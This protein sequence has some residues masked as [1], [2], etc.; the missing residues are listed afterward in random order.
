MPIAIFV[1][2][3]GSFPLASS[4][5]QSHTSGS[6]NAMTKKGSIAF[7]MMPENFQSVLSLAKYVSVEPFWKNSIQKTIEIR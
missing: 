1:V 5:F 6:E 3:A 2:V 7:E 4:L